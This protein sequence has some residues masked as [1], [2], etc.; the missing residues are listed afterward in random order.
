[1]LAEK[2]DSIS[3]AFCGSRVADLRKVFDAARSGR[4]GAGTLFFIDE[5][6]A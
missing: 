2:T 5:T 6:T 3:S 4:D 1:M